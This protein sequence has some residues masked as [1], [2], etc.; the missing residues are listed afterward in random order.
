MRRLR[1]SALV[2]VG[3]VVLVGA[4]SLGGIATASGEGDEIRLRATLSGAQEV[5]PADPDGT[6]RARVELDR[7]GGQVCFAVRFRNIGTP[8]R[9]HIH[10]GAAGVNGAIV[11]EFF[12]LAANPADPRHDLLE[13]G[14]LDGCVPASESTLNDIAANPGGFY[15]NLHNARFPAG[16]I[17]GQLEGDS[18]VGPH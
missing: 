18:V 14:R 7:D 9:G 1:R 13:T 11:V 15:V 12:E 17:R 16:A 10:V 2:A 4:V 5:P 3:A 6:G 8:N